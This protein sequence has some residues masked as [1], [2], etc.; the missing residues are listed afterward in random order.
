MDQLNSIDKDTALYI[1]GSGFES[2]I[3]HLFSSNVK[4]QVNRL[5]DKKNL[6]GSHKLLLGGIQVAMGFASLSFAIN[7]IFL[8]ELS[9]NLI[10]FMYLEV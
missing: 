9:I 8:K 3:L 1:H 4:F 10:Y 2:W 5:F 7:S 6:Y